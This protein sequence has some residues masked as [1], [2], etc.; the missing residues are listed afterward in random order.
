[1]R[2]QRERTVRP[3]WSRA[4]S[5]FEVSSHVETRVI[6]LVRTAKQA[7]RD[8]DLREMFATAH[9]ATDA[10]DRASWSLLLD[11]TRA[12]GRNDDH[13]ERAIAPERAH[14]ERGFSKVAVVVRSVVG[15]LQVERHAREDGVNLRAFV[16]ENEALA[17]LREPGA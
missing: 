10:V 1:M 17:W 12:A 7:P 16:D 9:A 13:F 14:L 3:L 6:K 8:V 4:M 2:R 5:Y 11:L 15:R